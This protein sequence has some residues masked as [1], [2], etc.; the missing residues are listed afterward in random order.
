MMWT[1]LPPLIWG[2]GAPWV[3]DVD[4]YVI[5]LLSWTGLLVE[6][7]GA[8]VQAG[9]PLSLCRPLDLLYS[10]EKAIDRLQELERMTGV[11]TLRCGT[12]LSPSGVLNLQF[13]GRRT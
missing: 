1:P 9:D 5:R 2:V 11:E 12:I 13:A 7:L 6:T 4:H 8:H 10:P 3:E